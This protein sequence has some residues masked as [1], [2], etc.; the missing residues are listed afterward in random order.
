MKI[1]KEREI[2]RSG[3]EMKRKREKSKERKGEDGH[4]K[5]IETGKIKG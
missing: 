4:K 1:E 5:K 3:K 2:V